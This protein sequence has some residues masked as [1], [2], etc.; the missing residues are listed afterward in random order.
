MA[1]RDGTDAFWLVDPL[2]GTREFVRRSGEFSINI[3]LVEKPLPRARPRPSAAGRRHLRGRGGRGDAAAGRRA[4]GPDRARLPGPEGLVVS[5]AASHADDPRLAEFLAGLPVA[6]RR[7]AG[8][9]IKFC[10]VAAGEVDLYPAI[11][12]HLGSRDHR[13]RP[14]RWSRPRGAASRPLTGPGSPTETQLVS[15]TSSS[16]AGAGPS[17]ADSPGFDPRSRKWLAFR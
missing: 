1:C 10:L 14:R 6:A 5:T 13:G 9:A 2:D 3:G 15:M 12:P 4:A 8:S 11:R 17:P 7:H 16:R